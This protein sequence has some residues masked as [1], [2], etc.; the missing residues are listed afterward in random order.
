M[1]YSIEVANRGVYIVRDGDNVMYVGSSKC[2]LSTLEYNH[3]NWKD[4]YGL[5]GRTNFREELIANGRK[6]EFE[7]LVEP[8]SCDAQ[9]IERIEGCLIRQLSPEL[10]WDK[11]P[12]ASSKKYGRY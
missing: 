12:V 1:A 3:R 10:N 5:E 2:M 9:T 8:F 6:W 4:K 11:D 7:W